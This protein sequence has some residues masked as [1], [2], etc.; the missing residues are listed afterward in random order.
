M[1]KVEAT[2]G[3]LMVLAELKEKLGRSE[4]QE[5]QE[6]TKEDI[7][8][9]IKRIRACIGYEVSDDVEKLYD[10]IYSRGL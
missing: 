4:N 6:P 5:L 3:D 2:E 8:E 1:I 10:K 7:A 9:V